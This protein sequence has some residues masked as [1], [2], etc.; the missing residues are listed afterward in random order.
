MTDH[1]PDPARIRAAQFVTAMSLVSYP[2]YPDPTTDTGWADVPAVMLL[3]NFSGREDIVYAAMMQGA[4]LFAD[5]L[6]LRITATDE[7]GVCVYLMTI[8]LGLVAELEIAGVADQEAVGMFAE[9]EM[10]LL[11]SIDQAHD[12]GAPV[13]AFAPSDPVRWI[14]RLIASDR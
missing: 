5:D 10:L 9:A 6:E 11:S 3:V 7:H 2:A 4:A 14:D 13:L 1:T 12:D 8:D